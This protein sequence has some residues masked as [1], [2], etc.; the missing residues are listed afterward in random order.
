MN[1]STKT[2][3]RES[4]TGRNVSFNSSTTK[5][6]AKSTGPTSLITSV[7]P[8]NNAQSRRASESDDSDFPTIVIVAIAIQIILFVILILLLI[9]RWQH[10]QRKKKLKL[11]YQIEMIEKEEKRRKKMKKMAKKRS[12]S[13]QTKTDTDEDQPN[14]SQE[15]KSSDAKTDEI[16]QS[17]E[18]PPAPLPKPLGEQPENMDDYEMVGKTF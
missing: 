3:L 13:K 12:G 9:L 6:P 18:Q 16:Q 2:P 11:A 10:K 7:V 8:I 1:P 17:G 14:L 15:R 4:S 5:I